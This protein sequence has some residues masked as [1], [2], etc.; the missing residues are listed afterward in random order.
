VLPLNVLLLFG[1]VILLT[2]SVSWSSLSSN[3]FIFCACSTIIAWE[4]GAVSVDYSLASELIE[5]ALL[6]LLARSSVTPES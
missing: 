6:R 1:D 5:G 2:I 3:A 4:A